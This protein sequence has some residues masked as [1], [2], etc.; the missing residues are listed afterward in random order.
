MSLK[1]RYPLGCQT[2]PSVKVKPVA[3]FSTW[4]LEAT[5]FETALELEERG[6]IQAIRAMRRG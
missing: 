2:G 5:S 4:T 3:I 6:Q 1:S